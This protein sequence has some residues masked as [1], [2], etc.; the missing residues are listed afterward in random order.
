MRQRAYGAGVCVLI[1][2]GALNAAASPMLSGPPVPFV[3]VARGTTSRVQAPIHLVIHDSRTWN[4]L[5][6]QVLSPRHQAPVV[7][8]TRDMAIA[9]ASAPVPEGA[10][11]TITRITRV[12]GRFLVWYTLSPARPDGAGGSASAPFHVVR[13]AR[14]PLPVQFVLL[15]TPPILRRPTAPAD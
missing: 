4:N 13:V 5:W 3:T 9:I 1:A 7:D 15:K 12:S 14:S 11:L 10:S 8:F 2:L 6:A